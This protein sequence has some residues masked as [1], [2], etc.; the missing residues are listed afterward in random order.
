[1][2][3]STVPRSPARPYKAALFANT[4][5]YLYNFRLPLARRLREAGYEVL[6]IS[7]PGD[8]VARMIGDGFRWLGLPMRRRSLNP[9]TEL[10]LLLRLADLLR[11]EQVDL[12]HGFTIKPAVYAALAARLAGVR[13]RIL[14]VAGLGH[15]FTSSSLSAQ[16]LRPLIA[17]AV[18][19]AADGSGARV[20]LQNPDDQRLFLDRRIA[21]AERIHLILGSGV[22]CSRFVPAGGARAPGPFR[23]LLAARLLWAKGLDD[24]IEA[25]RLLKAEAAPVRFVLAGEPDPGNP[26]SASADQVRAWVREGLVEWRGHVEDMA[27]LLRQMDAFAL[28][29][30]YGEG[31]PRGLIEAAACGLPLI[32]TDTPGCR[33]LVEHGV[34]GLHVT[35]RQPRTLAAAVRRLMAEP[36]TAWAMG[37]AAR[38]KAKALFDEARVLD[39]TLAVYAELLGA[40]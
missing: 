5:W 20:V 15:V 25:A 19:L 10:Q 3:A 40:A 2:D 11:R 34:E 32:T 35:P 23:V 21:P 7:P 38:A 36:D 37:A 16:A 28:P 8:Y 31:V 22:D 14:A 26:G 12:A 9:W 29:S 13:S 24:F 17:A 4:D 27:P 18:R 30:R 39:R 6:L 1:M 33:E